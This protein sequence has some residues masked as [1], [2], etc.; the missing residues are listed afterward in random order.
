[1]SEFLNSVK[2]DLLD[3][4]LLP[5]VAVVALALVA[6][7]AYAVLGGGST[8]STPAAAVSTGPAA[9]TASTGVAISQTSTENAVAETTGG[10]SVQHRGSSRNPFAPLAGAKS[11]TKVASAGTPAASSP[12]STSGSGSSTSSAGGSSPTTPSKPA[13]PAKPKTV[14]HVAVLFGVLPAGSTPQTVQLTPYEDLKLLTPL[15]SVKQP[16]IVFRGVTA[17]GKSATF[18]LVSEAILHG[19]AACLPSASQCEAIDLQPGQSEQLEYI[20]ASGQPESYELRIVSIS[21]SQASSAA[22]KNLLR[23]ESKGGRELLKH[24]GLLAVP[25]LRYSSQPGV[26]VFAGHP[27]FAARAHAAARRRNRR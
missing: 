9:A 8:A 11:S 20:S 25:D 1:M 16:L 24:A 26:L 2:A 19:N 7:V 13:T 21:P 17:G 15:P 12:S 5:L 27:A 14:Y 22:V 4:R 6:A 18:T 23:G 3:R 10:A